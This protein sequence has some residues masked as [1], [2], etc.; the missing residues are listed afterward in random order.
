MDE[1]AALTSSSP[2][3]QS[4]DQ[5]SASPHHLKAFADGDDSPSFMDVLDTI[6]PLQHIPIINTLYRELT[7]DVP[8]A[9]ARLAGGALYGGPLGLAL[10]TVDSI[11]DD[12]TG[13]D[14][15]GHA[16]AMLMDDDDD[17]QDP[18]AT[19]VAD[20]P[21][22]PDAPAAA[23][24]PAVA[25][26]EPIPVLISPIPPVAAASAAP[27]PA[28]AAAPSA[29]APKL[30]PQTAQAAQAAG[31]ETAPAVG[32]ST[33]LPQGFL[34]TPT[35]HSIQV[36]PPT[37]ASTIISTSNQR[38]NVPAAGHVLASNSQ[39]DTRGIA[40]NQA[41]QTPVAVQPPANVQP[42]T[43]ATGPTPVNA[44]LPDAMAKALDKY[45]RMNRITQTAATPAASASPTALTPPSM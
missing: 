18:S 28:A 5:T 19:K 29:L 45:D 40:V 27:Q 10:E 6:N 2:D 16:I 38:S 30:A 37:P 42:S 13:K 33:P 23:P 15:G 14:V 1:T 12:Q 31:S 17:V 7:G 20:A 9:V 21:K 22:T 24:A 36:V 26:A 39:T 41:G 8:G 44:W 43:P 32:G 34:P 3:I 11:I 25:A 4:A 35:R